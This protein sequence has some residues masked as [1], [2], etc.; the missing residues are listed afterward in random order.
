MLFRSTTVMEV[1]KTGAT[2]TNDLINGITSLTYGGTLTL[3][4][5]GD[6]LSAGDSFHLFDAVTYS[7][8]CATLNLPDPGV[9]LAWDTSSLFTSGTIAVVSSGS[10]AAP[11]IV[12][13]PL[14]QTN[15][16]GATV[17]FSSCAGGVGHIAYQWLF[18]GGVLAARPM[19]R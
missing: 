3:V 11:V 5:T 2:L 13:Q 7:G 9:G 14:S 19:L 18:N 16:V 10:P 6:P 4:A 1:N 12:V 8:G 15:D 17:N